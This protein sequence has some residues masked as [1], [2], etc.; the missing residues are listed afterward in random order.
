MYGVVGLLRVGGLGLCF[1]GLGSV[2]RF[3]GW[4]FLFLFT[5]V[6]IGGAVGAGLL[7]CS[8]R[9]AISPDTPDVPPQPAS[10]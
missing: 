3:R 1:V 4:R 5:A 6:E 10:T 2:G 7:A 9:S 8:V